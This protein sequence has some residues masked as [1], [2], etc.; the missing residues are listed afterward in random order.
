MSDLIVVAESAVH[1]GRRLLRGYDG[2]GYLQ[3]TPDARPLPMSD[4]DF[5]RLCS[6]RHYRERPQAISFAARE[7]YDLAD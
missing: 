1:P 4:A 5:S 3:L 6:M 7:E 2:R